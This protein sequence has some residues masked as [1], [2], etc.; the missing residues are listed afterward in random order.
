MFSPSG[1][2]R[3]WYV[4]TAMDC[5]FIRPYSL[6]TLSAPKTL[7][8]AAGIAAPAKRWVFYRC[9]IRNLELIKSTQIDL[10]C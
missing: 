2:G 4:I 6:L 5:F 3:S 9:L 10:S 7:I 1:H 8:T